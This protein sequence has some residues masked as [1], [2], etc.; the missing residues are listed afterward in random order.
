MTTSEAKA[1]CADM[2]A[3]MMRDI[4]EN[5]FDHTASGNTVELLDT[6]ETQVAWQLIEQIALRMKQFGEDRIANDL[7]NIARRIESL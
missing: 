4:T 7:D 5:S 3:D 6:D 2:S 1:I